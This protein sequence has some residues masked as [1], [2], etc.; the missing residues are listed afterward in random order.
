[1]NRDPSKVMDEHWYVNRAYENRDMYMDTPRYPLEGVNIDADSYT[2]GALEDWTE[3]ALVL[4]GKDQYL[5]LELAPKEIDEEP[6]QEQQ[7]AQAES[8]DS[9]D[10]VE[11]KKTDIGW[12]V[13]THPVKAKPGRKFT[14]SIKSK[15]PLGNEKI[16]ADLHW[17]KEA[18]WGG[19]NEG[20]KT[21]R[22]TSDPNAFEFD[23]TP[24][25]KEELY[26]FLVVAYRTPG[27]FAE[28]SAL[29]NANILLDVG[30][31]AQA[32][33]PAENK[34]EPIDPSELP[35]VDMDTN[36]FIIELYFKT[37]HSGKVGMIASKTVD[38]TGYALSLDE[39][40]TPQIALSS[41]G[42]AALVKSTRVVNDDQWHHVLVEI[43]RKA[44]KGTFYIDGK[45]AGS[46]ALENL[47]P[48]MSLSNNGPFQV[49]MGNDQTYL[50]ATIDFLR[51]SRGTLAEAQTTIEELYA[52]QFDGPFLRDFTGAEPE[53]KRD[54][55]AIELQ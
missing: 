31:V 33:K 4:N 16:R 48:Q 50:A 38:G 43:D 12:A 27:G 19:T 35:T 20:G 3:G 2:N 37:K 55:G 49:G 10:E 53:G 22:G 52:W 9:G 14:V 36:N 5:K 41:G 30:D 13:I 15:Q 29:G 18:G 11:M 23:F 6:G 1:S 25:E 28:K 17:L 42:N 44:N 51:V 26:Q 34:P 46:G 32:S 54:A 8:G 24:V 39:S 40:G 7:A 47:S 45:A 21:P